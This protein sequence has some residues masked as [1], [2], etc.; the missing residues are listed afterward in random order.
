MA[1]IQEFHAALQGEEELQRF[2]GA[3]RPELL[4]AD[5][6][7]LT[8]ALDSLLPEVDKQAMA[9]DTEMGQYMVD[10][11]REALRISSDGWVDDDLACIKPW[12]FELSEIKVPMLLYQGT[13]DKMVPYA[14]GEWLAKHLPQDKLRKYLLPGE[15]HISIFSGQKNSM[16]DE[17]LDI[18][19]S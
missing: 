7:G 6:A 10:M 13:E 19:K 8:A 9:A 2:C 18:A 11:F 4:Q 16:I 3:Q 14:Q 5:I 12:G 1:D 15:G 17:L